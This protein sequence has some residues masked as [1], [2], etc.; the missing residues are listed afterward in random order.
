MSTPDTPSPNPPQGAT[1]PGHA[2]SREVPQPPQVHDA[3]AVPTVLGAAQSSTPTD[4]V[5]DAQH[6]HMHETVIGAAQNVLSRLAS[7]STPHASHVHDAQHP[8]MHETVLGAAQNVFSRL[9]SHA[10]NP[11]HQHDAQHPHMQESVIGAAQNVLSR[12]ASSSSPH[13]TPA[14][15]HVQDVP[16]ERSAEAPVLTD[17]PQRTT[18]PTSQGPAPTS[19]SSHGGGSGR[20]RPI[21]PPPGVARIARSYPAVPETT[22]QRPFRGIH[23][24]H[25]R[26]TGPY[27]DSETAYHAY[28]DRDPVSPPM[29]TFLL[30]WPADSHASVP[31]SVPRKECWSALRSNHQIGERRTFQVLESR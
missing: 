3:S 8:H 9:T 26:T 16:R 20:A 28:E 13:A 27:A 23:S 12:L 2:T 15:H 29:T 10:T 6:P 1:S 11:A 30:S 18:E 14:I 21:T 17:V 22:H 4:H 5:H 31:F 19:I 24:V 7:S 25:R